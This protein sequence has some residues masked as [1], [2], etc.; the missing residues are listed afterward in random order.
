LA[1]IIIA[2]IFYNSI[3]IIF[4]AAFTAATSTAPATVAL[5]IIIKIIILGLTIDSIVVYP[6]N[7]VNIIGVRSN[8][9][10]LIRPLDTL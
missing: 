10:F 9:F 5:I 3:I 4:T 8:S 2:I 7:K 1:F 6:P